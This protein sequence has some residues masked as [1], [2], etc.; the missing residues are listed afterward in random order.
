MLATVSTDKLAVEY[1]DVPLGLFLAESMRLRTQYRCKWVQYRKL[2][3]YQMHVK[4]AQGLYMHIF[5]KN[6]RETEGCCHTLRVET[7]P[8][9]YEQY[10]GLRNPS[11]MASRVEFVS[12][13][14]ALDIPCPM[15]DIY[16]VSNHDRR[17]LRLYKG[18]R[19]FGKPHQ[20]KQH[21]YCRMYDKKQELWQRRGIPMDG[22]LTRIEMVYKPTAKI[23]LAD[24]T[25]YPPE[26]N[27][28]YTAKVITDW[29]GYTEKERQRIRHMQTSEQ[30]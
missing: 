11:K 5:Y 6:F 4:I 28:Y 10:P 19:Y 16:L 15:D 8:E 20:R 29:S 13:D 23:V 27:H 3:C 14:V 30:P 24:L 25:D 1:K 12:C 9:A 26:M 18:T 7:C 17:K 2:Y 21:A 22:E